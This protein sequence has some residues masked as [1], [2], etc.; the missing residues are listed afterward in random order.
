MSAQPGLL[1]A[2]RLKG[3]DTCEPM[4]TGSSIP[5]IVLEVALAFAVVLGAI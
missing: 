2:S 5:I 1:P 4:I 3:K